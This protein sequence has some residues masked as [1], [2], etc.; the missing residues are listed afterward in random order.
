MYTASF[1]FEPGTYD[2][3]FHALDALIQAAAEATH[4]YLGQENWKSADGKKINAIYYWASLE[5]LK[6]FSSHPQHLEAKRQ[7]QLWY[8]SFHIVISEIVKSYGDGRLA[9]ITPD[10]RA[11]ESS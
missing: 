9:H 3:K 11:P 10:Q 7:Y 8:K 1:I 6:Q 2:D 5:S 4:G